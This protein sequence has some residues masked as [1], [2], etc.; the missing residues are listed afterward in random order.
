MKICIFSKNDGR[1][2]EPLTCSVPVPLLPVCGKPVIEFTFDMMRKSGFFKA[3]ISVQHKSEAIENY[4]SS[5]S[6]KDFEISFDTGSISDDE[7]VIL[8]DADTFYSFSLEN[9]VRFHKNHMA[10]I[11]VITKSMNSCKNQRAVFTG[12]NKK[13]LSFHD[14]PDF[15]ECV[16]VVDSG[17][18]ILSG[19]IFRMF[20]NSDEINDM[21]LNHLIS[22]DFSV[23]SYETAGHFR[24]IKSAQ[25]YI[26]CQSDVLCHSANCDIYGHRTLDGSIIC[27]HYDLKRASIYHPICIGDNVKADA[28]T[29]IDNL[30]CIGNNVSIGRNSSVHNCV[31]MDGAYIGDCVSCTGAV[32][33]SNAVILNS[34]QINENCVIGESA[35]V[36][37]N[38]LVESNVSVWNGK[39]TGSNKKICLPVRYGHSS[40]ITIDENGI[41]G[42][43]NAVI[44]P[45]TALSAG[46]SMGGKNKKFIVGFSDSNASEIMAEAVSCGLA[47]SGSDV[48][49]IGRCISCEID[50][51]VKMLSADGGIYVESDNMTKIIPC[52]KNAL[53]L[54]SKLENIIEHSINNHDFYHASYN[55]FGK[56]HNAEFIKSVYFSKI[57]SIIPDELSFEVSVNTSNPLIASLARKFFTDIPT[58]KD[59]LLSVI[60]HISSDSRKVSAYSEMS[61]FVFHEKLIMLCCQ[62]LLSKGQDLKVPYGITSKLEEIASQYNR[63]IFRYS[64]SDPCNDDIIPPPFLNDAFLLCATVLR[65]L[66]EN[67]LSLCDA[68]SRLP[69]YAGSS[70]FV[71]IDRSPS[72]IIRKL[73]GTPHLPADG[74]VLNSEKGRVSIKPSRSG[75]SMMIY[76]ESSKYEFAKELC[77]FVEK[78]VSDDSTL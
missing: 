70:K 63:R 54:S 48:Y 55:E 67:K 29:V 40:D 36:G 64:P 73:C 19:R 16:S 26:K 45:H 66:S 60:F 30:S 20:E 46:M 50:F 23:C 21:F 57:K 4:L 9:A 8:T 51:A 6:H 32:I 35:V 58:E 37:E 68:V 72:E 42:E 76:A 77:D 62:D 24:H 49:N 2:L 12:K 38:T 53:P 41:S 13:I 65:I 15:N 25:D 18:Y 61:G 74:T 5:D 7:T 47:S 43:T 59:S 71:S 28:G 31:I 78:A 11:T 39:N 34:A 27:G 75:K 10:D 17:I 22:E 44:T 14:N 33:C 69:D 3:V 52:V 1:K 56:I